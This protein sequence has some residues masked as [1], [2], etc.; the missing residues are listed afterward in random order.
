MLVTQWA[1][2]GIVAAAARFVPVPMLDDVVRERAAQVAVSRTLRAHGRDYS[3]ELLAPLWG[4]QEGRGTGMR[5][6]LKALSMRVLLFPVRK[7]AAIF[8]AVCAE[9]TL[10]IRAW[11]AEIGDADP[12]RIA[13]I[14]DNLIA[15]IAEAEREG[16]LGETEG[17]KISLAGA[18]D[19]LA[20]ID[21]RSQ[22]V[23]PVNVGMPAFART[24]E[25]ATSGVN[26]S[27]KDRS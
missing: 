21:R 24:A 15:R 3:S 14:H 13:E 2:C 16:W 26:A 22:P 5:R 10:L 11:I 8:G 17:L 19:K 12:H 27:G 4:E 6:H 9:A 20:Q 7:Y 1:A 18:L 23:V 25:D